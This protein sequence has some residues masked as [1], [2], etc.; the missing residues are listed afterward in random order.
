MRNK[1][2]FIF[3]S[4]MIFF[5]SLGN[6]ENIADSDIKSLLNLSLPKESAT[7][8]EKINSHYYSLIDKNVEELKFINVESDKPYL[9]QQLRN[10]GKINLAD[11]MEKM[12]LVVT[13]KPFADSLDFF[14]INKPEFNDEKS[15]N[16][17]DDIMS[18]SEGMAR[19]FWKSC[20]PYITKLIDPEDDQ[21]KS[22]N[23]EGEY[24][25][26]KII[27]KNNQGKKLLFDKNYKLQSMEFFDSMGKLS[28]KEIPEFEVID[29]R[30]IVKSIRDIESQLDGKFTIDFQTIEGVVVPKG[31]IVTS[32]APDVNNIKI[33]FDNVSLKFKNSQN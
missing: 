9:I 2:L 14:F 12:N 3:S 21:I 13:Y 4:L 24:I 15:K 29:S 27:N 11:A 26:I 25:V 32:N 16:S 17:F 18:G 20:K 7:A 19:E 28:H 33:N 10:K 6:A 31:Y 8:I 22:I 30:Y 5:I 1:L 23:L